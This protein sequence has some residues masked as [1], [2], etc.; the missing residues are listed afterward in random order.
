MEA[1]ARPEQ[2]C[3][4]ELIGANCS[5][6]PANKDGCVARRRANA[7]FTRR[8]G[9]VRGTHVDDSSEG[10]AARPTRLLRR[11]A[12][13][14]SSSAMPCVSS[15]AAGLRAITTKS[16]PALLSLSL[17]SLSLDTRNQPRIARFTR[18]LTIALPTCLPAVIPRRTGDCEV[19]PPGATN[20]TNEFEAYR[21]PRAATRLKSRD[22][23]SRSDRL[24][25]PVSAVIVT[26]RVSSLR[27]AYDPWRD[28]ASGCCARLR[29]SCVRENRVHGGGEYDWADTFAS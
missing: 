22:F 11:A 4:P 6:K 2:R 5:A 14:L 21:S 17:V 28:G 29:F 7:R 3:D 12:R 1:A 20:K 23:R 27:G 15:S 16:R 10:L 24:K 26:W 8:S 18:F 13:P 25:R 9:F 19:G